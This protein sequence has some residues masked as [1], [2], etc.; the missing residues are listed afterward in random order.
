MGDVVSLVEKAAETI[1]AEDAERLAAKIRKNAFDLDDLRQQLRQMRKMGGL[2]GIMGML[3][4][5]G[6]IKKQMS[7]AKLDEGLLKRQEAIINSMTPKERENVNLIGAKRKLRIAAGSGTSVQDVN[8]LLK[9]Y[10]QMAQ[11]MKKVNRMGEKGM[12]R[13]G[14]SNLLPRR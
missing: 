14:L 3:P 5:V 6:Q 10:I 11:M 13:G 2:Q 4:G 12:M 9:Q 8:R 7:E 1:E